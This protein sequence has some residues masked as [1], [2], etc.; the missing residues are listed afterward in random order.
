MRKRGPSLVY[1]GGNLLSA[2]VGCRCLSLHYNA[3]SQRQMLKAQ[4]EEKQNKVFAPTAFTILFVFPN[5]PSG[6]NQEKA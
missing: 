2:V 3:G 1:L 5:Q 6:S 4:I